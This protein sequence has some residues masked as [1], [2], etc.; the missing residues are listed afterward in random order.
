MEPSDPSAF[1]SMETM[2]RQVDYQMAC[3]T[4]GL[5]AEKSV[6]EKLAKFEEDRGKVYRSL[7]ETSEEVNALLNERERD[8]ELYVD[9]P[10]ARLQVDHLIQTVDKLH[11]AKEQALT[12]KRFAY[13]HLKQLHAQS[14]AIREQLQQ[15]RHALKKKNETD[16]A[17][18]FI[19]EGS[20]RGVEKIAKREQGN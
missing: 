16:P 6:E 20:R 7:V 9:D 4:N 14:S 11:A 12:I 18:L 8:L 13:S 3:F 5:D 10:T 1:R 17:I 19:Q 2:W 15:L